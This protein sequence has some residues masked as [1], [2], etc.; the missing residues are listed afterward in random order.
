[1]DRSQP[2]F[3]PAAADV[4]RERRRLIAQLL[5]LDVGEMQLSRRPPLGV[6]K[7]FQHFSL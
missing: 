6:R 5:T 2:Y 7:Y 4:L 1:M 3:R